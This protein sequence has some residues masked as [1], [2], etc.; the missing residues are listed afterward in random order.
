MPQRSSAAKRYAEAL[1]GLAREGGDWDRW[2]RDLELLGGALQEQRLLLALQNER[3]A[4]DRK[5]HLLE[6]IFGDRLAPQTLNLALVLARRRRL[7]LVPDLVTWFDDLADRAQGVRRVTVTT[8]E[9][10]TADQRERLRLRLAGGAPTNPD[11][12]EVVLA[13]EVDPAL[14]GGLVVRQGDIIQDYSV[15]ARLEALR[16]R[17]N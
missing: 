10:L 2:R 8:A 5:R 4:T 15:R 9:P 16:E 11:A 13:E 3:L 14:I 17:L 7:D 1:A 6:T 12:R